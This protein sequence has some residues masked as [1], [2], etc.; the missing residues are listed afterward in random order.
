MSVDPDNATEA[1][2]SF[3]AQV[4]GFG[5]TTIQLIGDALPIAEIMTHLIDARTAV[6]WHV[7]RFPIKEAGRETADG[8]PHLPPQP[9][10]NLDAQGMKFILDGT[11]I[12]RLAFLRTPYATAPQE[13]GRLNFTPERVREFIGWGYGTEDQ[14]L[15]HAV[16]D[17]AIDA[18]LTALE[19]TGLPEV[20]RAKRPRLE[21]GDFLF[22][23]LL[24]RAKP[25]GVVVVQNPT[26]LSGVLGIDSALGPDR[27]AQTQPL[28]TL[29]TEG[30]PLA[31]GSDGVPN[32]FLNIMFATTHPARPGEALSREQAV[33]AYTLGS[34]FAEYTEKDKGHLSPGALAD[35][36][37]LSADVFTVPANDL[38]AITSVLTM[39]GGRVVHDAGV[40]GR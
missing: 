23:D 9:A 33:T 29:L 26:H 10:P 8:R 14:I 34:A 21:H 32:P 16:G 7:Y 15:M 38:P 17:G 37:V 11:P 25:L 18:Y 39:I 30:I 13:R 20:W 27:A 1:Y 22:P 31:L 3:A 12:E 28:K 35:L 24:A 2:R 6:R 4:A 5:V 19:K 36:A 40:I